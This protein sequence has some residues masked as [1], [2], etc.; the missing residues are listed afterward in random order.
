MGIVC[1]PL[2]KKFKASATPGLSAFWA[3]FGGP[4]SFQTQDKIAD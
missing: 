1:S 2:N 3:R 4:F